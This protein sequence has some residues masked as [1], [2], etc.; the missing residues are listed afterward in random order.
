MAGVLAGSSGDDCD[1][2]VRDFSENPLYVHRFRLC[3][4]VSLLLTLAGTVWIVPGYVCYSVE[5]EHV[6]R[7][8]NVIGCDGPLNP[9]ISGGYFSCPVDMYY[10][11]TQK[12]W[13]VLPDLNPGLQEKD[14]LGGS[15]RAAAPAIR[16]M[17][18]VLQCVPS[19]A[20]YVLD[21]ATKEYNTWQLEWRSEFYNTSENSGRCGG[22]PNLWPSNLEIAPVVKT[23]SRLKAGSFYLPRELIE[24][25]DWHWSWMNLNDSTFSNPGAYYHSGQPV[26]LE[27]L[28]KTTENDAAGPFNRLFACGDQTLQDLVSNIGCAEISLFQ[29]TDSYVNVLGSIS[30]DG[31]VGRLEIPSSLLCSRK[32]YWENQWSSEPLLDIVDRVRALEDL[33]LRT[34]ETLVLWGVF[35]SFC[36]CGVFVALFLPSPA[37]RVPALS[38]GS[39]FCL[40]ISCG[41]SLGATAG[42]GA[43]LAAEFQQRI[44]Y[45]LVA[46]GGFLTVVNALFLC[47]M[48]CSCRCPC[49]KRKE[50]TPLGQSDD[51][52]PEPGEEDEDENS[53][54][55]SSE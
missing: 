9:N 31:Q 47:C 24:S 42:G 11:R 28:W 3:G 19:T 39:A 48:C 36:F 40:G 4:L 54:E 38:A 20:I 23:V 32:S 26:S 22:G 44:G 8:L 27:N 37:V 41:L 21:G 17:V 52:D 14:S 2:A 5:L 46:S 16:Q 6:H 43:L 33:Q 13:D 53:E 45:I 35:L 10:L 15:I 25:S 49:C 34:V 50:H 51:E 18:R 29:S 30:P 1:V 7:H 12:A 55:E